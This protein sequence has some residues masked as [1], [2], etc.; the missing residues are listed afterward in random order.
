MGILPI[1][2]AYVCAQYWYY[3]A[4]EFG[5]SSRGLAAASLAVF[6]LM[7]FVWPGGLLIAFGAQA[8][9][10]LGLGVVGAIRMSAQ[11]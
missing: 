5:V 4:D 9:I 2:A 7:L 11:E 6:G 3:A 10:A 1:L 8:A